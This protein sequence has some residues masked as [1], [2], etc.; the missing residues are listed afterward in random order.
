MSL[1]ELKNEKCGLVPLYPNVKVEDL[2]ILDVRGGE[3][4]WSLFA[5]NFG[6][7]NSYL[8]TFNEAAEMV[9]PAVEEDNFEENDLTIYAVAR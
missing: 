1:K 7:V 5:N 8:L 4:I 3:K 6:E 9:V 2:D